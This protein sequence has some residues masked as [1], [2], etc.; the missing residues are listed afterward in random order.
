MNAIC[1]ISEINHDK[2]K[3]SKT[4]KQGRDLEHFPLDE[5]LPWHFSYIDPPE[6][7]IGGMSIPCERINYKSILAQ[8]VGLIVNLTEAPVTPDS[9]LECSTCNYDGQEVWCER[10]VFEDVSPE[11]DLQCLLLPLKDGHIPTFKQVEI[12]LKH[13]QETIVK[14]R[15]VSVHCHAGVGRT[16]TFLCIYLMV[17][18]GLTPEDAIKKLRHERPQSMQFNPDDWHSD[19]YLIR[20][21]EAYQR[22]LLQERYV[23]LYY[24][25]VILP[26]LKGSPTNSFT[27]IE[28]LQNASTILSLEKLSNNDEGTEVSEAAN[29]EK[30]SDQ[31]D[32][33]QTSD[34]F[35]EN[36]PQSPLSDCSAVEPLSESKYVFI[37]EFDNDQVDLE[38]AN[39]LE[40]MNLA[41]EPENDQDMAEV[42]CHYCRGIVAVGPALI[43]RGSLWPPKGTTVLYS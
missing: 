15:K 2:L 22:N 25:Q 1:P 31:V 27:S 28:T 17:K 18:Y 36:P 7:M 24:E 32:T 8:G 29:D 12:F 42:M 21:P 16:G 4:T 9:I 26:S 37:P 3:M 35:D 19:P 34:K 11:D 20:S 33:Q 6:L 13:A 39:I 30:L 10:D 40:E 38:L 5:D 14:G 23:H 43:S 41:K